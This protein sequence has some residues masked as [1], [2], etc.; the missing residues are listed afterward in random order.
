MIA[1]IPRTASS[2]VPSARALAGTTSESSESDGTTRLR[3]L[4]PSVAATVRTASM[5]ATALTRRTEDRTHSFG[6]RESA[7][8][9]GYGCGPGSLRRAIV[10]RAGGPVKRLAETASNLAAGRPRREVGW[11]LFTW[12][13]AAWSALGCRPAS[14]PCRS[15]GTLRAAARDQ[16]FRPPAHSDSNRYN[17]PRHSRGVPAR[18]LPSKTFSSLESS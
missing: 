17:R 14:G 10:T 5:H 8:T 2:V 11:V 12:L 9:Y 13:A 7:G 16:A 3:L 15:A 18:R 6:A 1:A 4:P